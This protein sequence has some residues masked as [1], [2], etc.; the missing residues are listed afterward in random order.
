MA[1]KYA[2]VNGLWS[3]TGTW[4]GGVKPVGGDT[5]HANGFNVDIDEDIT[6]DSIRTDAG[7]TA[8]AGG[9]F[10]WL[11][12][13]ETITADAIAGSS[14]CL[15]VKSVYTNTK[16]FIGDVYGGTNSDRG[17]DIHSVT[18]DIVG[19]GDCYGG[20]SS[21]SAIYTNNMS[22][23]N[24]TGNFYGGTNVNSEG[25][26]NQGATNLFITGNVYGSATYTNGHGI[27]NYNS[28]S[29]YITGMAV[30]RQGSG[31]F[32]RIASYAEIDI[33]TT[34]VATQYGYGAFAT[35]I[36]AKVVVKEMDW[37]GFDRCPAQGNIVFDNTPANIQVTV[38]Q[39]DGSEVILTDAASA[40]ADY[41]PVSGVSKSIVYAYGSKTGT[42]VLTQ[43]DVI[44]AVTQVVGDQIS[45]ALP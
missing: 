25:I 35:V 39:A 36:G 23:F 18:T 7:V 16:Y 22:S 10:D 41:P 44:N 19:V 34:D 6:V 15:L 14:S 30:G 33:I 37:N 38:E 4:D 21:S 8:S 2:V 24:W 20:T 40:P 3:A 9:S 27:Y 12:G 29:V 31:Y 1:E 13:C 45:A 17:I 32:S 42:A 11:D 43:G 5:V 28:G 26:R